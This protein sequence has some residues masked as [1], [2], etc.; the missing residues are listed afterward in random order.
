MNTP[1]SR[2][3]YSGLTL[4]IMNSISIAAPQVPPAP[5][6]RVEPVT[7]TYFGEAVTDRY[8]WMENDKDPAWLPYLKG[9]NDHARAVLA[10]L[11]RR[12]A[13]LTRIQQLSGDISAP[14][15]VQRAG[16]R[17]FFQQRPAG[18]N[19][20]KLFV[21]EGGTTR[22]LV[23]PTTLDT[24]G[25]H[26]SLDWWEPSHDGTKLAYGLSKDGSEDST[27]QVM[28]VASGKILPERIADTAFAT[29]QWL[30]DNSGF[31]YN[32]L[33]GKIDTPERYLDSRARFHRLGTDPA[34]D[35]IIMARN[36]DP[37][38]VFQ[39]IQVPIVRTAAGSD[40][41]VLELRDVRSEV[42]LLV[43]PVSEVLA[44]KAHWQSVADFADEVTDWELDGPSLYLLANHGHPRG[45][46]LKTPV[47]HPDLST[48]VEVL[49]ESKLV[50]QGLA[51][52]SDGIYIRAMD[53]GLATAAAAGADGTSPRSP[54]PSTGR[55]P[56]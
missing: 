35:P 49:A 32:Q 50:L 23:D 43:A 33:T 9:Q 21:V 29:P 27:L 28:D 6:A 5:V 55:F 7:D 13:L 20:Y 31:F 45:R 40:R 12:A 8:R 11:P 16:G 36:L 4:I 26:V 10:A 51:R 44:G 52:A 25:S 41:V 48:A 39:N 15:A 30:A 38:V 42:R 37:A 19:N 2:F 34:T 3:L 53:G 1:R 24:A 22:V 14:A 18:A 17:I 46:I 47:A 56:A 54:C